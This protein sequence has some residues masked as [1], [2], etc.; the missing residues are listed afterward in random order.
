MILR[1][2]MAVVLGAIL[3]W[4]REQ[5]QKA[6]GLRTHILIAVAACVFAILTIGLLKDPIAEGE[7]VRTDPIRLIEAVT[8]G[9]AFLAAGTIFTSG[10]NRVHGLTT[11]AG[12]WMAGAMGAACGLGYLGLATLAAGLALMVLWLL[13]VAVE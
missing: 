1:L 5:H 9:V 12:M 11:G 6:A 3:G 13:R 2:G 10:K 4:E 7:A 8:A